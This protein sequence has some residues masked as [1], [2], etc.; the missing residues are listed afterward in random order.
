MLTAILEWEYLISSLLGLVLA[1]L[2]LWGVDQA[3]RENNLQPDPEAKVSIRKAGW[4]YTIIFVMFLMKATLG[5]LSVI[6][7]FGEVGIF[8]LAVQ[9]DLLLA[10]VLYEWWTDRKLISLRRQKRAQEIDGEEALQ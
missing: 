1:L 6:G 2:L 7:E 5:F 9:P 4:R 3:R 10:L 8:V